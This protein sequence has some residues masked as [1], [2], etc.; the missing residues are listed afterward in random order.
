MPGGTFIRRYWISPAVT[1]SRR[2]HIAL[3]AQ[4]PLN[5]ATG[6]RT[7]QN[8]SMKPYS[9]WQR[10]R[11]P[12]ASRATASRSRAI[13]LRSASRS[14]SESGGRSISRPVWASPAFSQ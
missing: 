5:S 2:S 7:R 3:S 6:S 11:I 10:W 4:P 1:R 14:Q 13:L 9:D 12:S 8:S